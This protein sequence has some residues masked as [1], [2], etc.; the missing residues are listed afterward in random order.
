VFNNPSQLLPQAPP[1]VQVGTIG[2]KRI[3]LPWC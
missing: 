1:P 2:G 3:C